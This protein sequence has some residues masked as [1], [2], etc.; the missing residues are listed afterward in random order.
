MEKAIEKFNE[1]PHAA[2][3]RASYSEITSDISQLATFFLFDETRFKIIIIHRETR[4]VDGR[5]M[6]GMRAKS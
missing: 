1:R 6:S 3:N 2:G 4:D 5:N